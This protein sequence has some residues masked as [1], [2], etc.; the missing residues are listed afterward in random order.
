VRSQDFAW[1]A[2]AQW[3]IPTFNIALGADYNHTDD[4]VSFLLRLDLPIHRGGIFGRGSM[5]S[6]RWLPGFGHTISVGI[7]VPLWGSNIGKTRARHDYVRLVQRNSKR[8]EQTD[9]D[10]DLNEVLDTLHARVSGI[11]RT[12]Q[13]FVEHSGGDPHQAMKLPLD[14]LKPYMAATDD[15][16]QR[17]AKPF[18]LKEPAQ[19]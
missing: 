1:G 5:L 4:R 12:T 14:E 13:P 16:V 8:I 17:I 2:R 7:T 11:A 10:K 3:V 6:L 9:I 15:L 18:R 19:G